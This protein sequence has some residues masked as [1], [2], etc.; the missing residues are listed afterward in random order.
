MFDTILEKARDCKRRDRPA[1]FCTADQMIEILEELDLGR[2]AVKEALRLNK[3]LGEDL[4]EARNEIKRLHVAC[5]ELQDTVAELRAGG[6]HGPYP[7]EDELIDRAGRDLR[8]APSPPAPETEVEPSSRP[9]FY[10]DIEPA[11]KPPVVGGGSNF[12]LD[13]A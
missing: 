6:D 3:E 1:A 9:G 8:D 5:Q 13:P 4:D 10:E 2:K 11:D 7:D 12:A